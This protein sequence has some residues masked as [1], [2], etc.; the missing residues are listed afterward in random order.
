MNLLFI[1]A[2]VDSD[3]SLFKSI[4]KR[5][6]NCT[7]GASVLNEKNTGPRHTRARCGFKW[8]RMGE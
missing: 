6:E 2:E 4:M 1:Y 5:F 7:L 8:A 3:A